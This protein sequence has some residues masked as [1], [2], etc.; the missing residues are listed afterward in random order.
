MIKGL[1]FDFDGTLC[2]LVDAHYDCLNEAIAKIAGREYVISVNE[3]NQKY[4]GLST[5]TKLKMLNDGKSL[6]VRFNNHISILKQELTKKYIEN[7]IKPNWKIKNT[8]SELKEE[9]Y[10]IFCV[11]NALAQTVEMGLRNM[12]I[13]QLFD[14]I[15]GNDNIERQKPAPDIYLKAFL[16]AQLDPK[17]CLIIEDN[18]NGREAAYK[19]G[20]YICT[21]DNPSDVEFDYINK[22]INKCNISNVKI[23][24]IDSKINIVIPCAGLGSRF[25][26]EGYKLPKP[27][28]DVAG[29]PMIQRVVDN[30]NINGNFVFVVQ[31]EHYEIYNLGIILPLIA[32]GCK[33]VQT[34]GLTQGAACTTLLAKEFINNNDHLII[35]N[36][37][38]FVEWSSCDFMYSLLSNN[39]D[40]GILTF[41]ASDP[42]WSFAKLNDLG[43]VTE[44]AEKKPISDLATVGIY[45]FNR[46]SEYV[47]FAEQMIEKNI[48]TSGE[49]YVC[50]VYNEYIKNNKKIKTYNCSKMW[51]LGIPTDLKHFLQN[52]EGL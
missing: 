42:K 11:S 36:S 21:V 33:I 7:N 44:V 14:F 2:D 8:L 47:Q 37:D 43:Y 39:V 20:A 12:D 41:Q 48:R 13:F 35:A 4:N 27:L 29:K 23:P 51:G 10:L 45:Y 46:G 40:G 30:L 17:E 15:M 16:Q 50:P 34:E 38:Q 25:Q 5:K 19:S 6:P 3:H 31:K 28:I 26:R 32:P 52:Y 24:Y 22:I 1:F 49:F 9:G 18:R